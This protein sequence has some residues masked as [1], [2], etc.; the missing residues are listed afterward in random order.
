M[1]PRPSDLNPLS[2]REKD[3]VTFFYVFSSYIWKFIEFLDRVEDLK[4]DP[5]EKDGGNGCVHGSEW[6]L[7]IKSFRIK[8]RIVV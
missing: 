8:T 1:R 6:D 4:E 2:S 3:D 5:V 7:V